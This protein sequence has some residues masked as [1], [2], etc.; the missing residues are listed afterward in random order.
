M[1]TVKKYKEICDQIVD[2]I[3]I[4]GHVIAST[5]EQGMKKLKDKDGIRLA[6]VYPSYHFEG[7]PDA[8]KDM[9][10]ILFF[11]VTRQI[12]GADDEAELQQ[13][14]DAQEAMIRLKEYLFG[15]DNQY[16]K[17]FPHLDISSVLIDPEYNIF[18]GYIG[19]SMKFIC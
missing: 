3:D 8:Y 18:G 17:H 2:A 6:A 15:E 13:Y 16:C 1:I 9:H 14:S 7:E 19:W 11:M 10:E 4:D 5:E 12:E